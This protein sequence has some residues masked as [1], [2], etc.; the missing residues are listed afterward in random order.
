MIIF[1]SP[2]V[3]LLLKGAQWNRRLKDK[4][5]DDS[6]RWMFWP[7]GNALEAR[8]GLSMTSFPL[9]YLNAAASLSRKKQSPLPLGPTPQDD[10]I[11]SV[12]KSWLPA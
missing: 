10:G 1:V 7:R 5:D 8:L 9:L 3:N 12:H 4:A 11:T 6:L 2:L